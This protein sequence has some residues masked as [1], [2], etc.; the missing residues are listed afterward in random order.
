MCK[1]KKPK[2]AQ[3]QLPPPEVLHN[4]FTDSGR[5]IFG[6]YFARRIGRGSLRINRGSPSVLLTSTGLTYDP[7]TQE[8]S[9]TPSPIGPQTDRPN[10]GS[11]RGG[12]GPQYVYDPGTGRIVRSNSRI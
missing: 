12:G 3:I 8:P 10:A 5:G 4:P 7:T 6:A 1:P 9:A 2:P 11:G